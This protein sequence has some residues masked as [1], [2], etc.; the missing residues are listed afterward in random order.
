MNAIAAERRSLPETPRRFDLLI[1]GVWRQARGGETLTR[2]SPAHDVAVSAVPLA[3]PE[4]AADAVAAARRAFDTGPGP[5]LSGA[6]RARGRA[7][8]AD[9]LA[10]RAE[11]LALLDVLESGKPITQALGEITAAI[12]L[13]RYAGQLARDLHGEAWNSLGE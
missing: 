12:E 8:V 7:R 5:R 11:E 1:D 10:E 2:S 4:D 6:G 13:W 3:G 9:R